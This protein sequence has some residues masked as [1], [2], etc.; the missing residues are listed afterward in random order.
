[1]NTKLFFATVLA[2]LL[3]TGLAH[4]QHVPTAR[5]V[6]AH[7]GLNNVSHWPAR[8]K[9][10]GP[11]M[12][13]NLELKR[14][15]NLGLVFGRQYGPARYELEYQHGRFDIERARLGNV[16]QAVDASGKY[17]LVTVNALRDL[18]VRGALTVYGGVG[19]GVARVELPHIALTSG[20]RCLA[21]ADK[22]GFAFQGRIGAEHQ[23]GAAG[24][25]Y[26]QLGYMKLPGPTSAGQSKISYRSRSAGVISV[27]YR[28][29][30]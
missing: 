11:E 12:Q 2:A 18:Y 20:C 1:M 9:F 24:R 7:A 3:T 4:A 23:L 27:G 19:L 29:H 6:S 16:A 15:A 5:Y 26:A 28:H 8:V 13:A 25:V 22:T 21:Q 30:F 17:H 14:G 10:G